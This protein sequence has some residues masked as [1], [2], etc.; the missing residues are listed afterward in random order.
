MDIFKDYLANI[1][2]EAHRRRM[3]SI[4]AHICMAFPELKPI[5]KWNQPMFL[6]H[7]TF[8]IAFS[9]SKKHIS[10][11]P[12]HVALEKFADEFKQSGYSL[13]KMLVQ[14]PHSEAVNYAL[15]NDVIAFNI[16]YKKDWDKF[17]LLP[18]R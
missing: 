16:D 10:L 6:D 9:I 3:E 11:A 7:G 2:N 14:I 13:T 17:W 5:V 12:E 18:T 15:I 4:L 1:E 8:I